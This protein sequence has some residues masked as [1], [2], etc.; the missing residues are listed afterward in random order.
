MKML[1]MKEAKLLNL[2]KQA[3]ECA[4]ELTALRKA[5]ESELMTLSQQKAA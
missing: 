3:Q 1:T 4:N 5:L 2:L